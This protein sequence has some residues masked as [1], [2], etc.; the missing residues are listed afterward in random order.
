METERRL[1]NRRKFGYYMPVFENATNEILGYLSDISP[2]GF[3]LEGNRPLPVYKVYSMRLNL[4]AEISP[5]STIV[6]DAEVVW[7][8]PSPYSPTEYEY[9]FQIV[10]IKPADQRVFTHLVEKYSVAG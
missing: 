10:S 9:G 1:I 3:K 7:C 6:F 8:E 4:S 5:V 2:R